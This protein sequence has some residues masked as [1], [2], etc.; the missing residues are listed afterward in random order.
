MKNATRRLRGLAAGVAVATGLLLHAPVQAQVQQDAQGGRR[1]QQGQRQDPAQRLDRQVSM[2][3][4]RLQLSSTQASR[5]RGIL[6][7]QDEQLRAW[8]Q[9]HRGEFQRGGG[10]RGGEQQQG[11]NGERRRP[12]L[13]AELKAIRDRGE[14]QIEAVLNDRQRAEYRTLRE[15]RGQFGNRQGGEGRGQRGDRQGRYDGSR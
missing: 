5:I 13:P 3:T 12:E 6:Q 9:E 14:Q 1:W 7:R 2:L 10:R 11:A 4:E 8:R 15:Q